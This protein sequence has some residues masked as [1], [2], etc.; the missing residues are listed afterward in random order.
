M[1]AYRDEGCIKDSPH[2]RQ[3][4]DTLMDKERQVVAV[5]SQ[6]PFVSAKD[7]RRSL[8]LM[9]VSDST[10]RRRLREAALR[11]RLA[12]QKPLLTYVNK[13]ARLNFTVDHRS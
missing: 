9:D 3:P 2:E 6:K 1:R 10:I 4:R 13:T 11:S 7:V 12:A 8:D 5:V